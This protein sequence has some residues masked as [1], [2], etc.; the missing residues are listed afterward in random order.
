MPKRFSF[1]RDATIGE[2]I[3]M[4]WKDATSK[5]PTR[6]V[7]PYIYYDYETKL[8]LA[9]RVVDSQTMSTIGYYM[10]RDIRYDLPMSQKDFTL[11]SDHAHS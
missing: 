5:S 4:R 9:L 11:A 10:V 1:V 3:S 8:P 6:Y 2:Q 7:Y